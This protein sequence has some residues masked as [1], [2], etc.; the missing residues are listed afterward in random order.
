MEMNE[1]IKDGIDYVQLNDHLYKVLSPDFEKRLSSFLNT[2]QN[3]QSTE[4][5]SHIPKEE[6]QHL[7]FSR[8]A[9]NEQWVFRKSSYHIVRNLLRKHLSSKILEIGGWNGWLTHHLAGWGHD[10]LS[11]DYFIDEVNGLAAKKHYPQQWLSI[12]T[13][14]TDL[15]FLKIKFDVIV[16][17]HCLAYFKDP[18][19]YIS[20]LRS[21][22]NPNGKMILVGLTFFNNASHKQKEVN[23]FRNKYKE[24]YN[25]DI[26]LNPTKAYLE[27]A[28]KKQLETMGVAL[29]RYPQYQLRNLLA[30]FI[31]TKPSYMYGVYTHNS[32][33]S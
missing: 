1:T 10:V 19:E 23:Q 4:N 28:D 8:S 24:Q 29:Y 25:F 31:D 12:Q 6:Y 11:V 20:S 17:N 14:V 16:V 13:E 26:F 27:L 32:N 5:A 30:K 15:N 18:M 9:N 22:L 21:C 7:P 33:L 2:Y 3:I